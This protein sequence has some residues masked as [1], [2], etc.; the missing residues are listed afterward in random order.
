M[1]NRFNYRAKMMRNP[2]GYK[3]FFE[4]ISFL[5]FAYW[6]RT[7]HYFINT[8]FA[9]IT[10]TLQAGYVADERETPLK[11]KMNNLFVKMY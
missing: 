8:R 10:E 1:D 2:K 9:G 7:L 6:I 3:Y 5:N 11:Q 4:A